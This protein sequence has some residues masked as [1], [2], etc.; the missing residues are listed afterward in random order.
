MSLNN[1]LSKISKLTLF[2]KKFLLSL[3][4]R[5]FENIYATI[6]E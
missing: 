1:P 3:K 6:A 2:A 5:E 4:G